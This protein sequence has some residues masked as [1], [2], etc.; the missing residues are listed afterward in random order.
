VPLAYLTNAEFGIQNP[1]AS[2]VPDLTQI[3]IDGDDVGGELRFGTLGD[4]TRI[5]DRQ[6]TWT[7]GDTLSMVRGNH[8][9]RAGGLS[10][11]RIRLFEG[12]A[13]CIQ[14]AGSSGSCGTAAVC[15]AGRS[16]VSGP[17]R[18]GA[19]AGDPHAHMTAR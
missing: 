2:Q 15:P 14:I 10:V 7:V 9:L 8:S 3:T 11:P 1:F 19:M 18:S 12:S 17:V 16:T 5:F 13:E 6:T 4:G